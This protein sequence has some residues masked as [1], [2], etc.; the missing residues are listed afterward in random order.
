MRIANADPAS[1][2]QRLHLTSSTATFYDSRGAQR[3]SID[4]SG[5]T[6]K[7]IVGHPSKSRVQVI[8][9]G[10]VIF[11]SNNKQRVSVASGGFYVHDT[12]G[13]VVGHLGASEA[14]IGSL[15]GSAFYINQ[16][17]LQAYYMDS[18]NKRTKYFEVSPTGISYGTNIVA[19][20]SYVTNLGYQTAD[21]V[22]TTIVNRD[23]AQYGECTNAAEQ[24]IKKV[25]C[26]TFPKNLIKGIR[27]TVNFKNGNTVNEPQLQVGSTDSAKIKFNGSVASIDNP[28]R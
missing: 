8:D 13:T 22:N 5:K 17:S 2:Q 23:K 27:I 3:I 10:I 7:V 21:N 18:N 12:D 11:D 6:S 20:Q 14:R 25:I 26:A 16:S 19:S 28:V 9:D 4:S 1:A 24:G 15:T